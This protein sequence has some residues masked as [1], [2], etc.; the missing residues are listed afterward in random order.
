MM[1]PDQPQPSLGETFFGQSLHMAAVRVISWGRNVGVV[2]DGRYNLHGEEQQL[3]RPV[4][5][6]G[7]HFLLNDLGTNFCS[8]GATQIGNPA[9][10]LP[11][12]A[13]I[14]FSM[15]VP[16]VDGQV[17]RID[18]KRFPAIAYISEDCG[19][20]VGGEILNDAGNVLYGFKI[21]K[22]VGSKANGLWVQTYNL[23]FS[24][25]DPLIDYDQTIPF[26]MAPTDIQWPQVCLSPEAVA[27]LDEDKILRIQHSIKD[28]MFA[29]PPFLGP[30]ELM[31][32]VSR[33]ILHL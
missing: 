19:Y 27:L 3:G 6:L 15:G 16:L 7:T 32:E 31:A 11:Y 9:E 10:P 14:I 4:Y 22:G 23:I 2:P 33:Q 1:P 25:S 29:L 24:G 17:M 18:I 8:A 21:H 30:E 26:H 13:Y 12:M 20:F 28:G 5:V